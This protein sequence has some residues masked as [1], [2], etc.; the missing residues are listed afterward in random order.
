MPESRE[1]LSPL[2]PPVKGVGIGNRDEG[3]QTLRQAQGDMGDQEK[4]QQFK[5]KKES[6]T[7]RLLEIIFRNV[8]GL[9]TLKSYW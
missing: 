1:T 5:A 8:G 2:S 9:I 6:L 4:Y 3:R 7:I